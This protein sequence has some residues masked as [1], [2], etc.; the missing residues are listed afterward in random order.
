MKLKILIVPSFWVICLLAQE[1]LFENQC[2]RHALKSE[3]SMPQTL[4][5]MERWSVQLLIFNLASKVEDLRHLEFIWKKHFWR[6]LSA[7]PGSKNLK[8]LLLY[9]EFTALVYCI[10]AVNSF[11]IYWEVIFYIIHLKT[12]TVYKLHLFG[13]D[14]LK[15]AHI[16]AVL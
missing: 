4:K 16:Y 6:R 10:G 1:E 13:R 8:M 7:A 12:T 11:A 2:Y 3:T 5:E 15:F 14:T 9:I